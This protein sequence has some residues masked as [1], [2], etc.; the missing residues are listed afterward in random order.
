MVNASLIEQELAAAEA[1]GRTAM[2]A[3]L[4]SVSDEPWLASLP[5]LLWRANR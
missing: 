2:K 3:R 1:L 4:A 5:D